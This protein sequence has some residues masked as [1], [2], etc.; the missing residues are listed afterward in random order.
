[1]S[2]LFSTI[3]FFG[4]IVTVAAGI[5]WVV[6]R[7]RHRETRARVVC[8]TAAVVTVL[9]FVAFGVT[10]EPTEK[11]EEPPA[12]STEPAQSDAQPPAETP[13]AT[14]PTVT[15]PEPEATP[16]GTTEPPETATP[17]TPTPPEETEPA[18][19]PT[20]EP[21]AASEEPPEE[22]DP[23]EADKQAIEEA[24]RQIIADHYTNTDID[25][26][27]VN[28]NLGTE[29]DGDYILLVYLTWNVKNSAKM[30]KR[31]LAMY[32]EDFA[33]RVGQDLE[34]VQEVALFWTVPYHIETV[35]AVKYSYARAG[36][37]MYETD[38]VIMIQE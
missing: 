18:T 20:P 7:L 24:A 6:Q 3:T 38:C 10:H 15:T 11:V 32:S 2:I 22:A 19:T 28:E 25:A 31:V 27:S 13:P 30:T 21:P 4:F 1:M 23:I 8:I 37:G 34:N 29:D 36:A 12:S 14:P 35:T 16:Q 5:T 9:G 17:E 33:A 26:V